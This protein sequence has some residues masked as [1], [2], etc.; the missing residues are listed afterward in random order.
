MTMTARERRERTE[1][2][3]RERDAR[4]RRGQ[5][6]FFE[7]KVR[8]VGDAED[9]SGEYRVA[10]SGGGEYAVV[11]HAIEGQGHDCPCGDHGRALRVFSAACK[12]VVAA[13]LERARLQRERSERRL[14]EMR[15]ERE[16][17]EAGERE[18]VAVAAVAA[19]D[20]PDETP[21]EPDEMPDWDFGD[22]FD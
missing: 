5:D 4:Y 12:H 18:T 15:A 16:Q 10:G 11:L 3:R 7:G 13:R 9:Y 20:E 21:D 8:Y 17:E 22:I 2:N 19:A 6:L 14:A 1:R